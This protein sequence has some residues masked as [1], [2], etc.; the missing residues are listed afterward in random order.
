MYLR[1]LYR[2]YVTTPVPTALI[3]VHHFFYSLM[4]GKNQ[5]IQAQ[6]TRALFILQIRYSIQALPHQRC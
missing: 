1:Y 6:V 4:D 2:A 5:M 3:R